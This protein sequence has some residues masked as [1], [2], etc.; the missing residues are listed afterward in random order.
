MF[1]IKMPYSLFVSIGYNDSNLVQYCASITSYGKHAVE[2]RKHMATLLLKDNVT[3][4]R[5]SVTMFN[6][7]CQGPRK[8]RSKY[9]QNI[10]VI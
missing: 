7:S 1:V 9:T 3:E 6:V 5:K 8:D 10:S 2:F 4:Y